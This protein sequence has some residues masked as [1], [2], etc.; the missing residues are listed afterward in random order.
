MFFRLLN[1]N[2][3]PQP[4][5]RSSIRQLLD[6]FRSERAAL[7]LQL[8][9]L[10]EHSSLPLNIHRS[11]ISLIQPHSSQMGRPETTF[12][13]LLSPNE[14]PHS[15]EESSS[16][17]VLNALRSQRAALRLRLAELEEQERRYRAVVSP[18]RT[19]PFEV[20]GEIFMLSVSSGDGQIN[21]R[22]VLNLCLVCRN[23]RKAALLNHSLWCSVSVRGRGSGPSLGNLSRWVSR[24]G[25]LPK[26]L[27]FTACHHDPKHPYLT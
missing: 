23:W 8:A 21:A 9:E 3:V 25:L 4:V 11:S 26:S 1:S 7:L 18:L 15:G 22:G 2:E 5:E 24:S 27:C 10:R 17:Q 12:F 19:L 16:W 6:A 13:R 14:V 20:L